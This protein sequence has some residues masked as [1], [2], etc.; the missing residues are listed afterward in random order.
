MNVVFQVLLQ[1]TVT[2]ILWVFRNLHIWIDHACTYIYCVYSCIWFILNLWA[3][4]FNKYQILLSLR[5]PAAQTLLVD[6]QLEGM[7]K[8]IR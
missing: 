6:R 1:I 2:T 7:F 8:P 4:V 3:S 5:G